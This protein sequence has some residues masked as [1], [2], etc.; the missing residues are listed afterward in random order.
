ML[1]FSIPKILLLIIVIILVWNFFK[2][3]EKKNKNVKANE[4]KYFKDN[5][6]EALTECIYCGGFYNK[7]KNY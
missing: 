3:F 5:V 2:F 1:G 4:N 6:E 7:S